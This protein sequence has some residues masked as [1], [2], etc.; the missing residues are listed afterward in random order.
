MDS[1]LPRKETRCYRSRYSFTTSECQFSLSSPVFFRLLWEGKGARNFLRIRLQRVGLV[2]IVALAVLS[3]VM[4][5]VS[6]YNHFASR[7]N[8]ALLL[9]WRAIAS[10]QI[11]P[12]WLSET[13]VHLW[14]LEYLMLFCLLVAGVL[15]VIGRFLPVL[16]R[17]TGKVLGSKFRVVAL[18]L[19][20]A[21]GLSFMPM[22]IVPYPGSFVPWLGVAFVYGWFYAAGWL[23]HR[24]RDLLFSPPSR[25]RV[26]KIALPLAIVMNFLLLKK[27]VRVGLETGAVMLDWMIAF[28]TALFVWSTILLLILV[29]QNIKPV[30]WLP[31]LA[32]ASYWIYLMHYP[33]AALMPAVLG[34][35]PVSPFHQSHTFNAIYFSSAVT[36]V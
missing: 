30:K 31:Y 17:W 29:F 16:D 27:R 14:F 36:D 6:V 10:L 5:V 11:Q 26:E 13:P 3:P 1:T 21:F 7:G 19:P 34:K 18:A 23:I 12:A 32:D 9:T 15:S 28:S 35:W 20:T 33:F 24:Q 2:W 8:N 22:A 4:V 25:A